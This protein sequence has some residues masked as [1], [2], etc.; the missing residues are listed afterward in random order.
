MKYGTMTYLVKGGNVLMLK[1][2]SRK[3]DPNSGY[4][5]LP[6]GKLEKSEMGINCP[7]GRL[8]SAIREVREE[9]GI[10]VKDATLRGVILFDN[11]GRDFDNWKNPSNFT[12][13]IYAAKKYSGKAKESDEGV[14][15]SVPLDKAG[16]LPSNPGDKMM[17]KW[18]RTGKPF[19]GVIKHMGKELD[20]DGTFVNFY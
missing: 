7:E 1:K 8:E 12:V 3:G 15:Y 6:G 13:Y 2:G 5:T 14:P 16:E 9:T 11:A 4:F 10:E 18:L 19:F 17:Y 20:E